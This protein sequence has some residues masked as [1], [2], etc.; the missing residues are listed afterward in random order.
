MNFS[1]NRN[2]QNQRRRKK[3]KYTGGMDEFTSCEGSSSSA[4]DYDL[5]KNSI[6]GQLFVIWR[7]QK[8]VLL[9]LGF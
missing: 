2:L 9:F 3:A 6:S 8:K 4:P 1:D 7:K 5:D